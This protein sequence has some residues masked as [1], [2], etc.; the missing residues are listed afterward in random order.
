MNAT[1]HNATITLHSGQ[2]WPW[3]G[4]M[5]D[6]TPTDTEQALEPLLAALGVTLM[7]LEEQRETEEDSE[8]ARWNDYI[9]RTL[10]RPSAEP[11]TLSEP[12]PRWLTTR[13]QAQPVEPSHPA[14]AA[15]MDL[16]APT[17][18]EALKGAKLTIRIEW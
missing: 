15:T 11:W 8:T 9:S 17:W 6:E 4:H 13:P 7:P 14:M 1:P 18:L 3:W 2:C 16:E 5:A 10:E 12:Q